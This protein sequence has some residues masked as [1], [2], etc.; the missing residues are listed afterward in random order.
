MNHKYVRKSVRLVVSAALIL[1]LFTNMAVAGE[2]TG[3]GKW[4]AGSPEA[5]LKG[6]SVCAFSGHQDDPDEP[7]FRVAV[8]QSWG[9]IPKVV[10]DFLTT[11]GLNPGISCNPTRSQGEPA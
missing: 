9:L 2:I 6:K 3:S 8:A 4:I 11:V 1:G 10:R 5:P 7:G